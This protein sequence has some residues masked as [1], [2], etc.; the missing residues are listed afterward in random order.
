[1][2][3]VVSDTEREF[4]ING[5]IKTKFVFC[6]KKMFSCKGD[7]LRSIQWVGIS[8]FEK[9]VT[10]YRSSSLKIDGTTPC[11]PLLPCPTL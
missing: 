5:N 1:M 6:S 3:Y 4:E 8:N 7:F 2:L 10:P 9:Q 11:S